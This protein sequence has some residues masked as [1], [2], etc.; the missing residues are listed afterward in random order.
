MPR[1]V[2]DDDKPKVCEAC[3][4]VVGQGH[5]NHHER[6]P[7]ATGYRPNQPHLWCEQR[8]GGHQ[9]R[10]PKHKWPPR[11]PAYEPE[12][13][14]YLSATCVDCGAWVMVTNPPPARCTVRLV[15][16][17]VETGTLIMEP[18]ETKTPA[19]ASQPGVVIDETE[20]APEP[21]A[22]RR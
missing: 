18:G 1:F 21:V 14:R 16:E 20:P 3:G 4:K 22:K 19:L 9:V 5:P 8:P 12:A 13:L 11:E 17:S 15:A 7:N 6:D 10:I 2:A